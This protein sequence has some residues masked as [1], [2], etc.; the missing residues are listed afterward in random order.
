MR[1]N[2][3]D[4]NSKSKVIDN[5]NINKDKA[6]KRESCNSKNKNMIL[7]NDYVNRGSDKEILWGI[8]SDNNEMFVCDELD[9]KW[10]ES[11]IVKE[12]QGVDSSLNGVF[13]G[14]VHVLR[15]DE[16]A[17]DVYLGD[18][19]STNKVVLCFFSALQRWCNSCELVS[20]CLLYTSRCV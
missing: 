1:M 3:V 14:G 19:W 2:K 11:I 17:F 18:I 6:S 12:L 16:S 9:R 13:G 4:D 15:K 10:R 7:E 20:P 5:L 8:E